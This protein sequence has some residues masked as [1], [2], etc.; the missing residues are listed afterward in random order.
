MTAFGWALIAALIAA[1]LAGAF[2]SGRQR[3]RHDRD[4]EMKR[5]VRY[6]DLR[7]GLH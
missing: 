1:L 5:H 3:R 7:R 6:E 4:E 2:W